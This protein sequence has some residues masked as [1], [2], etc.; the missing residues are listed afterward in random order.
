MRSARG[1][2]PDRGIDPRK[3]GAQGGA[4][5]KERETHMRKHLTLTMG[6]ALAL[7]IGVGSL[8][9]ASGN[10]DNTQT[11]KVTVSPSKVSKTKF[12]LAKM[13]S[14]TTTGTTA[15]GA[16]A[17]TPVD[18][19]TIFYDKNIKFDVKGVP[20]C[21]NTAAFQA[22]DTTGAKA[23]CQSS[24]VGKGFSD[25]QVAGDP[26]AANT[27]S[28]TITAFN[29][30]PA[31]SGPNKGKPVLLLHTYVSALGQTT[32]L[33]GT[34]FHVNSGA[35]GW[36]LN[37]VVPPLPAAT[38]ATNFDVKIAPKTTTTGKGKHRV[39][40][41][42]VSARC[43]AGKWQFKGRFHYTSDPSAPAKSGSLQASSTQNC[44]GT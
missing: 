25:V 20:T 16:F 34:L 17:I 4:G 38:A 24:I 30:K 39:K 6:I 37:V 44:K 9:M 8:A 7:A 33:V 43:P 5:I 32:V 10:T 1:Q 31:T 15:S 26:A 14:L 35:Y 2:K 41:F 3:N 28:A 36:R 23:L 11:M 27:L 40:H 19:A 42:Y 21:K 13:D 29:S 12:E 18:G 22:S